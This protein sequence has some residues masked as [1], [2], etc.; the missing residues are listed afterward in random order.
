[1]YN[2]T[3]NTAATDDRYQ[4]NQQGTVNKW[5]SNLDELDIQAACQIQKNK[6][7]EHSL[8]VSNYS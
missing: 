2:I 7:G 8:E 1:M 6:Y 4:S 5:G 3:R